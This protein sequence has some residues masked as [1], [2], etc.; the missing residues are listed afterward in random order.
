MLSGA[1]LMFGVQ[2]QAAPCVT[3]LLVRLEESGF[4][5]DGGNRSAWATVLHLLVP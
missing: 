3:S 5:L 1:L 4:S 2:Q